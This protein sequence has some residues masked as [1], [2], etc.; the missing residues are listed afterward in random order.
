MQMQKNSMELAQ[1]IKELEESTAALESTYEAKPSVQKKCMSEGR[2]FHT[3]DY[4]CTYK[5]FYSKSKSTKVKSAAVIGVASE[6]MHAQSPKLFYADLLLDKY[7]TI[8]HSGY[9]H[10]AYKAAVAAKRPASTSGLPITNLRTNSLKRNGNSS[11]SKP[12]PPVR[13]SSSVS[14]GSGAIAK[15]RASPPHQRGPPV[16]APKPPS[17]VFSGN[18]N[19]GRLSHDGPYAELQLIQNSIKHQQQQKHN[20]QQ[21]QLYQQQHSGPVSLKAIPISPDR[22]ST[23][24]ISSSISSS[25]HYAI[26]VVQGQNV[27]DTQHMQGMSNQFATMN[28]QHNVQGSD[29]IDFPLPP[30]DDELKEIEKI[31]SRPPP[32]LP[33]ASDLEFVKELKRRV[34]AEDG[35]DV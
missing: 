23:G 3:V 24:S 10:E 19:N 32:Q 12:P 27:S 26:S 29:E 13:R 4:Y 33:A 5:H 20:Y 22:S 15:V 7:F 34:I 25:S 11:A 14:S 2:I 21:Q 16:T 6:G 31:Y 18:Q 35:S 8:P 1:A 17:K 9:I 28:M 30:T